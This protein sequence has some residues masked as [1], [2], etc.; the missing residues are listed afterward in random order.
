MRS[1]KNA[2]RSGISCRRSR[3]AGNAQAEDV[4]TK[5]KIAA[6]FA[7]HDRLFQITVR[8]GKNTYIDG[9]A[10]RAAHRT[11]FFF[12]DGP[13]HFG[14]EIDRKLPNFVQKHRSTLCH[15]QKSILGLVRS[16]ESAFDVAEQFAFDQ[17]GD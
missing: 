16:G 10:A 6:E 14:L 4:K 15:G 12:L 9:Y 8:G 2:I 5:I 13:Q 3:S 1:M 17:G 7:L 11:N